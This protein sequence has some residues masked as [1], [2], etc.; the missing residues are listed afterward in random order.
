MNV[1]GMANG[2]YEV[3][4]VFAPVTGKS[5][6]S[7]TVDVV[8][9]V[10]IDG[11]DFEIIGHEVPSGEGHAQAA[12]RPVSDEFEAVER[13]LREREVAFREKLKAYSANNLGLDYGPD[14]ISQI[15]LLNVL[16]TD[17]GDYVVRVSFL[18]GYPT[19][20]NSS[21][22]EIIVVVEVKGQ[23]FEIVRHRSVQA[24]LPE[25]RPPP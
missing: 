23:D 11:D 1:L 17:G 14:R 7:G 10:T 3:R 15:L 18:H 13:L 24:G 22:T 9:F 6:T 5:S 25:G 20:W 12:A 2:A 16:G 19:L 21:E 4:V 8:V